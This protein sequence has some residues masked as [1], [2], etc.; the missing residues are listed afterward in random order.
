MRIPG[1]AGLGLGGWADDPLWAGVYDWTVEHPRLGGL[2]WAAGINSDLGRL[3]DAVSEL[4]T[5]PAGSRV[6]D[7]P[8]GGGV[9]LRG[10]RPDQGLDYVAADI[11]RRMLERARVSAVRRGVVD[12]VSLRLADAAALPF[13]D[14]SFD[15]VVSFMGLHCFP[16]P[17]SA[18]VEMTRVLRPG[19][20]LT[21][22]AILNDSGM[23][24]EP[25]RQGGRVSG[26]LGPG[27]SGRELLLW[28]VAQGVEGP[29]L[30]RSGAVGYFR[31]L[32][33]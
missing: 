23:R 6:L 30:V 25:M 26:L 27:C 18:V 4:G 1:L 33:G 13:E 9:A 28:L 32:K 24:F 5:L 11:S 20:L 17:A 14:D 3:Y 16:D 19:G 12:Q 7:V 2:A 8:V 21:G 31:G 15:A 29:E 22:S 10:V